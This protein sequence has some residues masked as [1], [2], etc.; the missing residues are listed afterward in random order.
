MKIILIQ[1]V[2]NKKQSENKIILFIIKKT[3]IENENRPILLLKHIT[4]FW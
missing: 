4:E 2:K 1:N 3:E